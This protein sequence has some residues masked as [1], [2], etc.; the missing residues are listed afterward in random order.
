[1]Y[2]T[3]ACADQG[4]CVD[5]SSICD[6]EDDCNDGSDESN[7]CKYQTISTGKFSSLRKSIMYYYYFKKSAIST[8]DCISDQ[9]VLVEIVCS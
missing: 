7:C 9:Q 2:A 4:H 1:M 5:K 8:I 6:K 3:Q